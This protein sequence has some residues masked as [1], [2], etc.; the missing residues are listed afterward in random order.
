[1]ARNKRYHARGVGGPEERTSS[2]VILSI[3]STD[4]DTLSNCD[5]AMDSE[6]RMLFMIQSF[7]S[8][9]ACMR[10]VSFSWIL[11]HNRL[12]LLKGA[13]SYFCIAFVLSTG[14]SM[15]EQRDRNYFLVHAIGL[16]CVLDGMLMVYDY[17]LMF[18]SSPFIYRALY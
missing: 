18:P 5:E 1:M 16:L 13:V 3:H 12:H 8:T 4:I 14:L 9:P 7:L 2:E 17:F 10:R 15:V 6:T 11:R